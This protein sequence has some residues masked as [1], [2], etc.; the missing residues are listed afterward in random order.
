MSTLISR[1]LLCGL[2]SLIGP[3]FW[4]NTVILTSCLDFSWRSPFSID[5]SWIL[6]QGKGSASF[7][8]KQTKIGDSSAQEQEP[9]RVVDIKISGHFRK[10][11]RGLLEFPF[12]I[13]PEGEIFG[14]SAIRVNNSNRIVFNWMMT[15]R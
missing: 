15:F 3:I 13:F 7:N 8:V 5:F 9:F 4:A 12:M 14:G 1:W 6:L 11:E 2:M 10:R